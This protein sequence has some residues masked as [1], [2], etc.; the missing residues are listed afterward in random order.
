[1][2]GPNLTANYITNPKYLSAVSLSINILVSYFVP[3]GN[4]HASPRPTGLRVQ[5]P[6]IV[7]YF[8]PK[9]VE[10]ESSSQSVFVPS[11]K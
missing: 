10:I 4:L 5:K 3:S 11:P 8:S 2:Y 7:L 9:P 6:H 1:M